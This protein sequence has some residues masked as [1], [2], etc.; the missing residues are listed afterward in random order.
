M[1]ISQRR[2]ADIAS[3]VIGAGGAA[4][5]K[6]DGRVFTPNPA[7]PA[8]AILEFSG[9]ETVSEYFGPSSAEAEFA[10]AYFALTT[11]AP[12]SRA[13]ALQLAPHVLEDR[14][15]S[16]TGGSHDTLDFFQEVEDGTLVFIVDGV[17][18]TADNIDLSGEKS[19]S[20]VAS[21]LSSDSTLSGA[22]LSFSYVDG[23]FIVTGN[24]G[25]S[26]SVT[27]GSLASGLG[28]SGP[29][30]VNDPGSLEQTMI[31]AWSWAQ[32]RNPSYGSAFFL[33]RGALSECV[34]VAEANAALNV[35][36]QFYVQV[37]QSEAQAFYDAMNETASVG[38]ILETPGEPFVAHIPMALMS[39]TNYNRANATM[40]YMFRTGGVT[41]APQVSDDLT[42]NELDPLRVNYYGQTAVAGSP[43]NFFQ[44]GFLLGDASAPLDM[45]VH[46]NEQWMKA[47]FEQLWFDL[48]TQTRGIPANLDGRARGVQVIAGVVEE[49]IN[50]GVILRGKELTTIQRIAVTDASNDD[51]A[52]LDVTNKGAWY[53]VAINTRTG[54]SGQ[55]EYVLDYV[56][57]YAK[58]DWVRK[59]TGS[60]N[61]V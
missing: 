38:L 41:I 45:S 17:T 8:D 50:N 33:A 23:S 34:E 27:P 47:R 29:D 52:W 11:P 4:M 5:Q 13:S 6:L 49:A 14:P 10:R 54:E 56:L 28:I 36:H 3:A 18:V 2:Y 58:G 44:R 30:A 35:R 51:L 16:I 40:N 22:G 20:D 53:S 12:V 21:E 31:D 37:S 61:L 32:S 19:F 48:M 43:I 15:P 57:I 7:L 60:H 24:M 1:P 59:V 25:G 39:A 46:A 26:I 55:T 9:A 42:A